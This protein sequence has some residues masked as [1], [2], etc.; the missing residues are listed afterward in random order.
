M[1]DTSN[2]PVQTQ[3]G[4]PLFTPYATFGGG[5]VELRRFDTNPPINERYRSNPTC[6]GDLQTITITFR[7][8]V[9]Q[10]SFGV[11]TYNSYP[12]GSITIEDDKGHVVPVQVPY[13]WLQTINWQWNDIRVLK[14]T[15]DSSWWRSTPSSKEMLIETAHSDDVDQSF[16]SDADQIGAKRRRLSQCEIVIG[17]SQVFCSFSLAGGMENARFPS[18]RDFWC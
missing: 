7:Y 13:L 1:A 15:G 5:E 8:P 17:I 10:L 18:A 14:I 2:P 3:S 9:S 4:E 12:F 16:R 11:S 6:N